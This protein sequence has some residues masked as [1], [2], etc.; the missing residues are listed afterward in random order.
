VHS[1]VG[2]NPHQ[3]V[4][5]SSF[6]SRYFSTILE[7]FLRYM[8]TNFCIFGCY[9]CHT[10]QFVIIATS[11]I[12]RYRHTLYRM[13]SIGEMKDKCKMF[14]LFWRNCH[15]F[16]YRIGMIGPPLWSSGQSSWLQNGDVL[17]FLWGTNWIYICYVEERRP[18]L[19]SSGQSSWLHNWDMCFLW[20]TNWI[21]M[22]YVEEDRLCGLVVR[23]LN[24]RSRGPGSIPGTTRFSEK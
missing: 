9:S 15:W 14:S 23:V 10:A 20:S 7:R 5:R 2:L 16:L 21:Y 12:R 18:P 13:Y 6:N 24:Y 19:R 3:I 4:H 1:Y 11:C 17:W 22:C 8:D